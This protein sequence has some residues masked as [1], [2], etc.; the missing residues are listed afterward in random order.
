LILAALYG[1][2][3]KKPNAFISYSWDDPGLKQWVRS[4]A[5]RLTKDSVN[6]ALDQWDTAP[7]D[8]LP[9]FM[10]KAIRTND[11][12]LVICTP[13]YKKKTET[14]ATGVNY[15]GDIISGEIFTSGNQ[16]KFVPI[17][18][19]GEWVD[20]APP[21]F[22]GKYYIDL[23]EGDYF[24]AN[25]QDLLQALHQTRPKLRDLSE[26]P[27]HQTTHQSAGYAP[28]TTRPLP[29][30]RNY[31]YISKAKID[32]IFSQLEPSYV[33]SFGRGSDSNDLIFRTGVVSSYI[34]EFSSVGSVESPKA[35]F[36][37][38]IMAASLVTDNEVFFGKH[39][40]RGDGKDLYVGLS[41][42][43]KHMI[44]E[45]FRK[46]NDNT[47]Y[48]DGFMRM[49]LKNDKARYV[50]YNSN[51]LGFHEY[52]DRVAREEML[53]EQSKA[54]KP[55]S[56]FT[57]M[58]SNRYLSLG[59]MY[60]L[61]FLPPVFIALVLWFF[62]RSWSFLILI[63][64]FVWFGFGIFLA[65][66][67]SGMKFGFGSTTSLEQ[68]IRVVVR[69]ITSLNDRYEVLARTIVLSE[70]DASVTLLGS[71]IYVALADYE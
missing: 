66:S 65:R 15:E 53:R 54:E 67:L 31:V 14:P 28:G 25:Y 60:W 71:P 1:W 34:R 68:S 9:A 50:E 40:E 8:Q 27:S 49:M 39:M 4:L 33:A 36:S 52:L 47:G 41:G 24:E 43:L 6:V 61:Y 19:L 55:V 5:F 69:S 30:P 26:A 11:F 58:L 44:G 2:R 17:L 23:R 63:L 35:Y 48:V 18:R 37:G 64:S 12:V 22:L 57:K 51:T 20:S 45:N 7:G 21:V 42:S 3:V 10:S 70:D 46:L 56:F 16:R 32:Q 13:S 38:R 62:V 29:S 59:P